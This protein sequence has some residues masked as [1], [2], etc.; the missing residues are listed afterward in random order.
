MATG[1]DV[2]VTFDAG[3][4]PAVAEKFVNDPRSK[5]FAGDNDWE[6][7]LDPKKKN[8]GTVKAQEAA[9]IVG[10]TWC[11]PQFIGDAAGLSDF[12]DL[13]VTAGLDAVRMQICNAQNHIEQPLGMVATD[14]PID[15][16]PP[17]YGDIPVAEY[18]DYLPQGDDAG[19]SPI[20]GT[21]ALCVGNARCEGLG[22]SSKTSV[23]AGRG[24]GVFWSEIIW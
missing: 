11:V 12:N 16:A 8:A 7:A 14:S 15:S 20:P 23:E 22:F 17:D 4:M 19:G 2:V 5:I 9:R 1:W 10:G 21:F 6:T 3:N 18:E 13:H 24:K